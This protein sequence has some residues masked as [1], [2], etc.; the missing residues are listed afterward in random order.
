MVLN[1]ARANNISNVHQKDINV[2]EEKKTKEQ[3]ANLN[4]RS[5][6]SLEK[7]L[8]LKQKSQF[9]DVEFSKKLDNS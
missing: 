4:F 7:D 8:G 9:V 1:S 5:L 2:E 3:N 6:N